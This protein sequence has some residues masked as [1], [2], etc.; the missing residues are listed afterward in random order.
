MTRIPFLL[1]GDGPQEPTGLGRIARDLGGLLASSDLPI[2]FAQVGGAI[3]PVWNRWPHLPMGEAE[4]GSDWGA[5]YIEALWLDLFGDEPGVLFVVWDPSRLV[6]YAKLNLPV[7]KWTYTA[8]DSSNRNG[9]IAGPAGWALEQ[10]DRILAYGRWAS[11]VLKPLRTPMPYLPHGL[12]TK[13][14][15][16]PMNEQEQAWVKTQLGPQYREGHLLV[17][18]VATNQPRKDLG[19][20]CQTLAQLRSRGHKVYGWLHTDVLVKAWSIP[21]L[22]DDCGLAKVIAVSTVEY[23]D[24]QLAC[25]YQACDLTIAPGLGEGF[26]YPIVESLAAGTPC[27]HGDYAGGADL[28]PKREWRVPIRE[29]RLDG[30]YALQ[31]PVFRPEDVASAAQRALCWRNQVGRDTMQAYLRGSVCYLDWSQLQPRWMEWFRQGLVA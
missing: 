2:N 23:S 21:Q 26:C 10:F 28:I 17:G 3:P 25:M 29:M 11:E 27:L 5:T 22:V 16:T 24:R 20:F 30:V 12:M 7:Q 31:R 9:A 18:C 15:S 13:T 4:R 19:L 14:Y 1:V 8:I 6:G